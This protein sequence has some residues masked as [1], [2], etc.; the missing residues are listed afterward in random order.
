[1]CVWCIVRVL[2]SRLSE[3]KIHGFCFRVFEW[4]YEKEGEKKILHKNWLVHRTQIIKTRWHHP[5][6]HESHF[7][8][9]GWEKEKGRIS[10]CCWFG[11]RKPRNKWQLH[12]A[13]EESIVHKQGACATSKLA[14]EIKRE[15]RSRR[16]DHQP[17]VQWNI[18]IGDT[19]R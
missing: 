14:R 6:L 18:A 17:K 12:Q 7:S 13:N 8:C 2:T 10:N 9:K 19:K 4:P 1:M 5:W 3:E 15:W 16:S 11:R